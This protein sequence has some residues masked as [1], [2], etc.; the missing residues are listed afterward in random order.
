MPLRFESEQ[1]FREWQQSR[2]AAQASA[3]PIRSASPAC[4]Q[5]ARPSGVSLT[6]MDPAEGCQ[7]PRSKYGNR[8]VEMDGKKFDSE[9]EA[10]VY[11]E[12]MARVR[13]GEL[14]CVCR[15]VPFDL[16]GGVRYF[17]DFVTITPDMRIEVLDAK[18]EATKKNAVYIIK[19]KQMKDLWGITIKE[20]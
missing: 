12:L 19:K 9:H 17:A 6:Q 7:K 20:V 2:N 15:Q 18:S 10:R 4:C 13:A 1:E 3:A 5:P 11:Q 14:R 16:P 8:R